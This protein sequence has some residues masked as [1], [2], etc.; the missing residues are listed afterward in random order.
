M[1]LRHDAAQ[2]RAEARSELIRLSLGIETPAEK[3]RRLEREEARRL[4]EAKAA[5]RGSALFDLNA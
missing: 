1:T 5:T 4:A 2:C 3:A